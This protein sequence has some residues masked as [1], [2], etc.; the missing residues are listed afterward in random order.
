MKTFFSQPPD[1]THLL[2]TGSDTRREKVGLTLT[3]FTILMGRSDA[4]FLQISSRIAVLSANDRLNFRHRNY[5][6][7][8]QQNHTSRCSDPEEVES[9]PESKMNMHNG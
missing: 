3:C 8:A 7:P 6:T 1:L 4:I 9:L 2:G 5:P